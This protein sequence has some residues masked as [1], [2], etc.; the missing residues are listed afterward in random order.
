M[1]TTGTYNRITIA[2]KMTETIKTE[3]KEQAEEANKLA[4]QEVTCQKT[5]DR[6][7]SLL[8]IA[9]KARGTPQDK[10][11]QNKANQAHAKA[12]TAQ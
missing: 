4:Q 9:K 8:D 2:N 5:C 10:D 12:G 7:D 6:T 11:L 3:L 1:L